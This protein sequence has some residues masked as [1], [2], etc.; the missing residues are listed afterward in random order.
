ML[1]ACIHRNYM[2][3]PT[4]IRVTNNSISF[5]NDGK[6]PEGI[7]LEQLKVIHSSNPR[8]PIIADVCFKGG[9]IDS[10]GNG[11][12]KIINL[13]K[14]ENLPE[15]VM[16]ERDGGFVITL[17]KKEETSEYTSEGT[18]E[19]T[20]EKISV[21]KMIIE[22]KIEGTIEGTIEATIEVKKK[23]SILLSAI[24]LNEGKRRLAY[25]KIAG[26]SESTINRYIKLLIENQLVEFRGE[27]NQTGG[28]FLTSLAKKILK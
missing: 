25:R 19:G 24:A 23:L 16:E 9:Y 6:L 26:L 13:C 28:Y 8:N 22:K 7:T 4:Q 15:P 20:I 21:N 5:W 17:F 27:S 14:N 11:T 2:G 1:N 3:A 10:W 12:L 18:I